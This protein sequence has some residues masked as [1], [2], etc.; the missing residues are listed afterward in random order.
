MIFC[1]LLSLPLLVL[2][3]LS[4]FSN[5][6]ARVVSDSETKTLPFSS[7]TG[8]VNKKQLCIIPKAPVIMSKVDELYDHL[9]FFF[10]SFF[11]R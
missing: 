2:Q 6:T 7:Y 5:H 1:C 9:I 3:V 10:L 11:Y 8:S 4:L